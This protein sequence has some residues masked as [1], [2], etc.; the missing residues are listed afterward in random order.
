M[1]LRVQS[2]RVLEVEKLRRFVS[3]DWESKDTGFRI[4]ELNVSGYGLSGFDM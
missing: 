4:S 1:G 3:R 2:F